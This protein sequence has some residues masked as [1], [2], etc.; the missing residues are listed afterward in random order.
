MMGINFLSQACFQQFSSCIHVINVVIV[1][2]YFRYQPL[3]GQEACASCS[4]D[5]IKIKIVYYPLVKV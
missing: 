5:H 2:S 1:I 4:P 3:V